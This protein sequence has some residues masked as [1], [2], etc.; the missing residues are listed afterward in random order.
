M[1]KKGNMKISK[2]QKLKIKKCFLYLYIKIYKDYCLLATWYYRSKTTIVLTPLVLLFSGQ[3][4]LEF[5]KS[6][7]TFILSQGS[8]LLKLQKNW[9]NYCEK[10]KLCLQMEN[11]V[12]KYC[13][14]IKR[15]KDLICELKSRFHKCISNKS[16]WWW[17]PLF[18]N[19]T[20]YLTYRNLVLP[21]PQQ[22]DWMQHRDVL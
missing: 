3:V 9:L 10:K 19:N 21:H 13:S 18:D 22:L 6:T 15:D 12:Q 2:G 14:C 5:P 11:N 20:S 16:P 7:Q 17:Q 8:F 4:G 1:L